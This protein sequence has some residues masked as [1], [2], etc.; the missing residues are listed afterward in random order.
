MTDGR[1][2]RFMRSLGMALLALS[3][4]FLVG[5]VV[6]ASGNADT[7][8]WSGLSETITQGWWVAAVAGVPALAGWLVLR[9]ARNA[10]MER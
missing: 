7:Y 10:R 4:V 6:L 9:I 3:V 8:G 5:G 2:P 1:Y